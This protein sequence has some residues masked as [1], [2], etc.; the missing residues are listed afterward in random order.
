MPN[1]HINVPASKFQWEDDGHNDGLNGQ[2]ISMTSEDRYGGGGS[3][4]RSPPAN[5]KKFMPKF[6]LTRNWCGNKHSMKA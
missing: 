6:L 4:G 1:G 2:V 5:L 3:G